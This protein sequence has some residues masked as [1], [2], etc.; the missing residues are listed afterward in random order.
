MNAKDD[1]D[2]DL[3]D[4]ARPVERH[5]PVAREE[6]GERRGR[7]RTR[8]EA[9]APAPADA[10]P[11][12][13]RPGL[14]VLLGAALVG[15]AWIGYNNPYAPAD[16]TMAYW[17]WELFRADL[18]QGG[19]VIFVWDRFRA[20]A[21]A[22]AV[23]AVVL[24]VLSVLR[25]GR[26]R[27][28][29]LLAV[30]GLGLALFWRDIAVVA[31]AH[32][33]RGWAIPVAAALLAGAI[34][35]RDGRRASV[36]GRWLL[37]ALLLLLAGLLFWPLSE[38]TTY[39]AQAFDLAAPFQALLRG[40]LALGLDR[41]WSTD[42]LHVGGLALLVV[43]A[44]VALFGLRG[45]WTTP[46]AVLLLLVA[47]LGPIAGRTLLGLEVPKGNPGDLLHVLAGAEWTALAACA[48]ILLAGLLS[49]L[50]LGGRWTMGLAGAALGVLVLVVTGRYALDGIDTSNVAEPFFAAASRAALWLGPLMGAFLAPLAAAGIDPA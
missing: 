2:F 34:I 39:A 16:G 21:L 4:E 49:F 10:L 18:D 31:E 33:V 43:L 30:S 36:G 35:G 29:A 45:R 11:W 48:A 25:S 14:L 1:R 41:L 32:G 5:T 19:G 13:L 12:A 47:A 6:D 44:L 23:L 17:P 37:L 7:R 26:A 50:G 28:A 3:E 38:R 46:V 22:G 42:G 24:L 27:G 9:P 20:V 8:E 15:L 40:D